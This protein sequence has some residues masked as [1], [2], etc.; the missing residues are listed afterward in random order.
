MN[1][2]GTIGI[3][4][5]LICILGALIT[6]KKPTEKIQENEELIADYPYIKNYILT[7]REFAFY[8]QLE[9]IAIKNN[10]IIWTQVGVSSILKVDRT[11]VS[12]NDLYKYRNKISQKTV[13]FVL[14]DKN[15]LNLITAIELDDKTHQ[16]KERVYRDDFIN[17]AFQFAGVPLI[18]CTNIGELEEQLNSLLIKVSGVRISDGSP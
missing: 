13:D 12:K 8:K 4:F 10:L 18:R 11:K 6:K 3:I 9:P 17:N 15:S 7:K 5:L 1:S 14:C 16:Y 2:W